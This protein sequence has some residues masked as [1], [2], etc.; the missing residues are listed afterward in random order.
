MNSVVDDGWNLEQ[1]KDG[2]TAEWKKIGSS[3]R[4][5]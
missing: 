5:R 4:W 2:R 3:F 1:I